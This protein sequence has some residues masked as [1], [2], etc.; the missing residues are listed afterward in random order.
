MNKTKPELRQ[1]RVPS[2][3]GRPPLIGQSGSVTSFAP[4]RRLSIAMWTLVGPMLVGPMLLALGTG[5]QTTPAASPSVRGAEPA[6]VVASRPPDAP[7]AKLRST[8][9]PAPAK[10]S[11]TRV[12]HASVLL[13]FDGEQVL[14]DPWFN[15]SEEYHHGEPLGFSL[16]Q[17][18]KLSAVVASHAHFDHFDIDAFSAYPDKGVP[19]FVAPGMTTAAI[20][21]GFTNVHELATWQSGHAGDLTVTAAPGA[22]G[23]VEATYVIQG[24]GN[25]VYFGGDSKLIPALEDDLPQRFPVIDLALLSV[26]GLQVHGAPVVMNDQEAA[27]LAGKLHA[28]VAVPMHYMFYGGA[29]NGKF[30]SYHGTA[31]GFARAAAT[32]APHTDVRILPPGQT[33]PIL[34]LAAIDSTENKKELMKIS[35]TGSGRN[36]LVLHG[37]GGPATMADLVAHL[38][39]KAHVITPTHPGW[40]GTPRPESLKTVAALAD[41]YTRYLDERDLKDV[42]VVG[43]SLGGWLGA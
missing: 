17:L 9:Q 2:A 32:L 8:L 40:D 20:K 3:D 4:T 26:N 15:D 34:H 43:S 7:P 18:P 31:E 12:G 23:V 39:E 1:P 36:I 10:L 35:E 37:G 42:L 29:I 16:A 14:T 6:P 41:E 21:A 27:R 22:H 38:A 19:F 28:G 25:T 11:V 5:C 30:L 13:D 24:K 33:L